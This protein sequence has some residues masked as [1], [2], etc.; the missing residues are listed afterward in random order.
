MS[1]D[2]HSL[3]SDV[4]ALQALLLAERQL[5][6]VVTQHQQFVAHHDM[7]LAKCGDHLPLY[8]Q[9]DILA[10]RGVVIRRSSLCDWMASADEL[11]RPLW[12][13]M[14]AGAPFARDSH[15]RYAG[16][17]AGSLK[18]PELPVLGVRG[19]LEHPYSVYDFTT[20]RSRDGPAEFLNGFSGYL[21]ADAYGDY[22]GIYTN[23]QVIEVA[24]MAHCRRYWW[25]ARTS[26]PRR[27]HVALSYIGRLYEL[28]EVYREADLTGE[29]LR[30]RRQAQ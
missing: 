30:A 27:A 3:P 17:V 28:E 18:D 4:V 7:V 12:N 1:T 11:A 15:R 10:R 22:D 23:G 24:C 26:D 8:R 13:L 21:Q 19:D 5:A 9:E 6:R 20:D 25:E 29:Q 16:Q 14:R 2:A